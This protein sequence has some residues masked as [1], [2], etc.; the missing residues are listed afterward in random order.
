MVKGTVMAELGDSTKKEKLEALEYYFF[1]GNEKAKDDPE[2][3]SMDLTKEP[4]PE[5]FRTHFHAMID[6]MSEMRV[7]VT[8][9]ENLDVEGMNA[10]LGKLPDIDFDKKEN[11]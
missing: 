5:P 8:V 7:E 2:L 11:K 3:K 9:E 10:Y 1:K 4:L 6:V